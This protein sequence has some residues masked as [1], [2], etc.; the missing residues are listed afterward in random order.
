MRFLLALLIAAPLAGQ[1]RIDGD[2]SLRLRDATLHAALHYDYVALDDVKTIDLLI[3]KSFTVRK[4]TCPICGA[5]RIE[6]DDPPILHIDL[7]RPAAKGTHV[8]LTLEYEGSI[9][10]EYRSDAEFLE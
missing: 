10:G 1:S 7:T 5:H 2:V 9:A 4:A 8:P 3:N 6:N